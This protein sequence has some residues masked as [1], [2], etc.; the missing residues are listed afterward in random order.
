MS[1]Q[2][3]T[4]TCFFSSLLSASGAW[5]FYMHRMGVGQG[6]VGFGK[7]NIRVGK[8]EVML[9]L[10]AAVTGLSVGPLSGTCPPLPRIPLPPVPIDN[11]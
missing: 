9:S 4:S 6:M 1:N 5:G 7:D 11:F 2:S 10:W 3:L 8:Q